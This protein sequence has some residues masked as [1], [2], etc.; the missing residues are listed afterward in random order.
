MLIIRNDEGGVRFSVVCLPFS[1]PGFRFVV[2]GLSLF[3]T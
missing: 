3:G 1:V 2:V